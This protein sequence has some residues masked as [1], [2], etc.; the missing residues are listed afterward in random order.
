[1]N[2]Q[3]GAASATPSERWRSANR[4]IRKKWKAAMFRRAKSDV[5]VWRRR[6]IL[7]GRMYANRLFLK[8]ERCSTGTQ[9]LPRFGEVIGKYQPAEQR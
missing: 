1:V 6:D 3:A 4:C 5:F 7:I 9:A 2:R 8:A